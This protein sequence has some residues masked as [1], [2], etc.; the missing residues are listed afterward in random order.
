MAVASRVI[1]Y[2]AEL[3]SDNAFIK[4]ADDDQRAFN[5][6]D[7]LN[8]Y[9]WS[10]EKKRYAD[11]GLHSK[12]VKLIT[13]REPNQEPIVIRKVLDEPK[14]QLVDDVYGYVTLFPFLMKLLP[15]NSDELATILSELDDPEVGVD[16]IYMIYCILAVMVSIRSSLCGQ[17][18]FLLQSKKH[19]T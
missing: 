10:S 2:L 18:L 8:K 13:I 19:S 5:D 16:D 7:T 6:I 14:K 9:H 3:S 17:V 11:Y 15:S 12:S 4:E 1:R